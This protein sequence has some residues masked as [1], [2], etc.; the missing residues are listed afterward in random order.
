MG[1]TVSRRILRATF[2]G[3]LGIVIFSGGLEA[4]FAQSAG[5]EQAT[6]LPEVRVTSTRNRPRQRVAPAP[7]PAPASAQTTAAPV[8]TTESGTGPVNGVLAHQSVTATKTDTPI[9]ETPQSISVVTKDQIVEQG[10]QTVQEALRY[11]PG[12]SLQGFGANAF[13]DGFKI[14][15]FDAPR[16]LDGLRLPND[17][18]QFALPK[19]EPYGL[20]RI[21]VLKGPSS[22]LYGQSDPGG[23]LNM[24]SKRPTVTPHYDFE[25]T[26]GNFNYKQGAFDIGGPIDKNGEFLYRIVGL[27]RLADTQTDFVQDN[28]L[29]IAP[30]FTWRP[31]TDTSFT[32]L[33]QYQKIDNKGYQQY[34][35]GQ[36]SFLPNPNGHVPYSRY[37]GEPSVDGYRLEQAMIGYAFEH[38]FDNNIQFRQNFRYTDVKNDLQSTRSEG[39]DPA[40][41]TQLVAR[42]YNYVKA[43]SQ[44]VALDNQLQA[45]FRTGILTHKVLVGADYLHQIG[46]SDYRTQGTTVFGGGFPSINAYNPVYGAPIPPFDS[47]PSFIR[48]DATLDQVGLYAQDQVKLDRWTLTLTGRQD[49]VN[50][51]LISYAPAL[52]PPAGEYRR[53][54][55]AQTGRVGLNYLFDFGLSPYINY[56]TSFVPNTGAGIDLKPFAPTTGDGKEIGVKYQPLGSNLMVTAALFEIN[57]NNVLTASPINPFLNVQTDAARSRGFEI[58]V[59]GNITRELEVI[60]GFTTIDPTVTKS[61][62]PAKVGKYLQGVPLDQASLWARYTWYDGAL[63]GFGLGAGIRYVGNSYGD[64]L[65][66]FVLPAYTLFDA[67][68]SY[69]LAYWR[70]D[71]K[72]WKAQINATNL[73]DTYYTVSCLTGLPYCGLGTSRTVLGTLRYSWN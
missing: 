59:R 40:N 33:S 6:E 22:G 49:F 14:R 1:L 21:E 44:N 19:I 3:A 61:L 23:L 15:G 38:R 64:D 51:E 52:F 7:A 16:Y 4:S 5:S 42:S 37:L 32:I 9:L 65:N 26:F 45:D 58:D 56:S 60:A 39:M 35:P 54:D 53:S 8:P 69:D 68:V 62:L 25:T 36:V 50:T 48:N 10:A 11:T 70:T 13:F 72:G 30:S 12:V 2:N 34:V 18:V 28:K 31:T 24:V 27:G 73:F 17:N 63:A 66:T 57:Q 20:E 71:L 41:P 47:L 67:S 29:F 46:N 55:S 43:E